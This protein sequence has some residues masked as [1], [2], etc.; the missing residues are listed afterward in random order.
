VEPIPT[1]PFERTVRNA[2]LDDEATVKIG[3]VAPEV[4]VIENFEPGV[5]EPTPMFPFWKIEKSEAPVEDAIVRGFVPAVPVNANDAEGVVEPTPSLPL[6]PKL[7]I[8]AP[9]EDA[10]VRGFLPA[11]PVTESD[12]IGVLDPIPMFPLEPI[13]KSEAFVEEAT[14]KRGVVAP[15]VP[16]TERSALG[17]VVAPT[18]MFPF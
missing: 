7:N 5:D 2:A 17:V 11:V 8:I 4:P 10:I 16:C 6:E 1:F 13:I 15:E 18:A 9:V 3:V 14:L 12:A